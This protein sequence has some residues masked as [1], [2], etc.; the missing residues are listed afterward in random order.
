MN[1]PTELRN[2]IYSV[3]D[4]ET[5]VTLNG[6][7]RDALTIIDVERKLQELKDSLFDGARMEH[8]M[9]LAPFE[10]EEEVIHMAVTVLKGKLNVI[11]ERKKEEVAAEP[12]EQKPE[13]VQEDSKTED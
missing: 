4:E 2:Y 9:T 10:D 8:M 7:F 13:A 12:E 3:D 6:M 1:N 5:L 11:E